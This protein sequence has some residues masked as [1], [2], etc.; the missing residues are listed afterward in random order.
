VDGLL[1]S[2]SFFNDKW[3]KKNHAWGAMVN[4]PK[5]AKETKDIKN[6]CKCVHFDAHQFIFG[7]DIVPTPHSMVGQTQVLAVGLTAP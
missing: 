4:D 5:V 6:T 1:Q 7:F 3:A 2:R